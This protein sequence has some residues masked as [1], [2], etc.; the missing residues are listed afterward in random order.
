MHYLSLI[1]SLP[2]CAI[3]HSGKKGGGGCTCVD[4]V[5]YKINGNISQNIIPI[6][7]L[8]PGNF[9][10]VITAYDML[11]NKSVETIRFSIED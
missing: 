4:F 8:T 1:R 5:E 6:K 9:E 11:K 7:G 10:I 2:G 3:F